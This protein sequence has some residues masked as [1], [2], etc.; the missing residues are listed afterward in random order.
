MGTMNDTALAIIATLACLL[1][2]GQAWE[3]WKRK[4]HDKKNRYERRR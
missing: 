1:Y 2:V 3:A 4:Y